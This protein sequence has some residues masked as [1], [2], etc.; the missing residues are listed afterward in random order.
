MGA[1][2]MPVSA[3]M[4][5]SPENQSKSRPTEPM[6]NVPLIVLGVIAVLVGTHVLFWTL[7]ESWQ[8]WSRQALL[9]I[10]ARL[11]GGP[12]IPYPN[13]AEI[14]SFLTYAL[15]H[16][17]KFHLASNCIWLL[18]FSTPLARRIGTWRYLLLIS[19]SAISGAAAMLP[20]HWGE[21]L[22]VLGASAAVSGTLAASIPII[23]A[24]GFKLGSSQLVDY[25]RLRVPR[26]LELLRNSSALVFAGVFIA[27][28]LLT[29]ASMAL[30]S[31]AFLE[32]RPIAWEAHL[33]GFFAGLILFYLLDKKQVS[34][35]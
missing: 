13:G 34:R 21:N 32:E 17:D 35:T 19:A 27:M 28:T 20:T 2:P 11:G 10:P 14:W 3:E 23:F 6:F 8:V 15:F 31:V 29:G 24:H 18:I 30:T 9:F 4:S 16:A 26:L 25:K 12:P 22:S 1:G 7:G 5:E 33:G